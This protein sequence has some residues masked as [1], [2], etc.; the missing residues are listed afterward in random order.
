MNA[1]ASESKGDL[2]KGDFFDVAC[3]KWEELKKK[4]EL[5]LKKKFKLIS[6]ARTLSLFFLLLGHLVEGRAKILASFPQTTF[7]LLFLI[8]QP[9]QRIIMRVV[10][11]GRRR[12]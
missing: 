12:T 10:S 7:R 5:S 3:A 11:S 6:I 4:T 8:T 9:R 2:N 1:S